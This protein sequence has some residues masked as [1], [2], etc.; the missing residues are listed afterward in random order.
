MKNSADPAAVDPGRNNPLRF[1]LALQIE[2]ARQEIIRAWQTC[3]SPRHRLFLTAGFLGEVLNSG[4]PL[5]LQAYLPEFLPYLFDDL[6]EYDGFGF[7]PEISAQIPQIL[8]RL[9]REELPEKFWKILSAGRN[10]LIEQ[11]QILW[12]TLQGENMSGEKGRQLFFPVLGPEP[13][14]NRGH[15]EQITIRLLKT[16]REN[17]FLIIP[18]SEKLDGYLQQQLEDS[19]QAALAYINRNHRHLTGNHE[20][21]VEFRQISAVYLG[22]SLGITLTLGFIE[23]LMTEYNLPRLLHL[24]PGLV[25]TGGMNGNGE[26]L[27]VSDEV[28][29]IKLRAVFFSDRTVFIVP[30]ANL[31]AAQQELNRLHETWPARNLKLAGLKSLD[32][33]LDRRSLV[34]IQKQSPPRRLL[35]SIQLH[36]E[37]FSLL[38]IIVLLGLVTG[39]LLFKEIDYNPATVD[40]TGNLLAIKNKAGKVLW[41]KLYN[42]TPPVEA[43]RRAMFRIFDV[44]SDGLN[45]ILVCNEPAGTLPVSGESGRLACFDARGRLLWKYLFADTISSPGETFESI[46][47]IQMIDTVTFEGHKQLLAAANHFRW[48]PSA[49]FRLDLQ[50]GERLPGTLWNSGHFNS[51][52]IKNIP[53]SREKELLITGYNNSWDKLIL[54]EVSLNELDG[55]GPAERPNQFSG[56]KPARLRQ[57]IRF[58]VTD[59]TRN[60]ELEAN[61]Y[62]MGGL[63]DNKKEEQIHIGIHEGRYEDGMIISY[64]FDYHLNLIQL[65]LGDPYIFRRDH[66]IRDGKLSGP[67]TNTQEY[68]QLLINQIEYWDG[69]KFIIKDG[70]SFNH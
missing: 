24:N 10:R 67:L 8:T 52:L 48:Y 21:I 47:H 50:T 33:L 40:N 5:L 62:M 58:P 46:Y 22:N 43:Y 2:E 9:S 25:S 70:I 28:M 23:T 15:L 59:L 17:R 29:A 37:A 3:I 7:P 44:N 69:E 42:Q 41:T 27:P 64:C 12:G 49:V 66:L 54:L 30:E 1:R 31:K 39:F 14:E 4:E 61:T 16:R 13:G 32:D 35:K 36:P 6:K 57:Y 19:W 34:E 18:A 68:H 45:E 11:E 51:G 20:I 38:L 63:I 26:I 56:K 55:A 53:G 65:V 60:F